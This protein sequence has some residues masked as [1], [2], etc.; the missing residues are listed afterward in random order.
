MIMIEQELGPFEQN[1]KLGNAINLVLDTR[2]EASSKFMKNV[3]F[4]PKKFVLFL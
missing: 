4:Y 2:V 3:L 1:I